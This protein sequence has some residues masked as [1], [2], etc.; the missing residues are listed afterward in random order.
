[1]L[2]LD[3]DEVRLVP[4]D[5]S[6]ASQFDGETQRLL[7]VIGDWARGIEHVG[8]TS[9]RGMRAKPIIDILAGIAEMSEVF[10]CV[11]PLESIGYRYLGE[12]GL[13]GRHFFRAGTPTRIHLHIVEWQGRLWRRDLLFRDYLRAK[14]EARDR[15]SSEKSGLAERF[16]ADRDAYQAGKEGV[17]QQLLLEAHEWI[18]HDRRT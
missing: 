17:I 10:R 5:D 14:T 18:E 4:H 1:M 8:S 2:G 11:A 3:D 7:S 15:Y 13:P 16:A 6:W 9:I 12:Y